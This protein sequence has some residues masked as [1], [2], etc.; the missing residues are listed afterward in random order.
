MKRSKSI[1]LAAMRKTS[2]APKIAAISLAVSAVLLQGCGAP[3]QEAHVFKNIT[4]C[5]DI[6]PNQQSL[7]ETAHIKAL[8]EAERT[9]PKYTSKRECET[10]FGSN[11]CR[12]SASHSSWFMPAMAGF[13][14]GNITSNLNRNRCPSYSYFSNRGCYSSSPV[15]TSTGG[16]SYA[17]GWY[18]AD[19]TRYGKT[20]SKTARV[21]NDVFTPKKTTTRT[22]SRGGFGSVAKAKSSWGGSRRYGGGW[23]G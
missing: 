4:E 16:G 15:F 20:S 9:A 23:G 12:T 2:V 17:G 5:V 21:S 14:L 18:G 10:E 8:S 11:N 13:M 19:G 1:N 3:K 7:C 6:N 22:I